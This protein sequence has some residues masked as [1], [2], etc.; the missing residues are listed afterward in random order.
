MNK[1]EVL[2][3]IRG[4]HDELLEVIARMAS[5]VEFSAENERDVWSDPEVGLSVS[6]IYAGL[7]GAS[8]MVREA[9]SQLRHIRRI[10]AMPSYSAF[11]SRS[12]LLSAQDCL[13]GALRVAASCPVAAAI[14]R[15]NDTWGLVSGPIMGINRI[16]T[17]IE[18]MS[19]LID[20]VTEMLM[21]PASVPVA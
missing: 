9:G 5:S 13:D 1:A 17:I 16:R 11:R 12:A 20:P 4:A 6:L 2:L 3:E 10:K 15:I 7:I 18:G 19:Q 14:T 8:E 21:A